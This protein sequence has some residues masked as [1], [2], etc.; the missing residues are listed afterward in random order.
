MAAKPRQ[1]SA[2]PQGRGVG[3]GARGQGAW[4]GILHSAPPTHCHPIFLNKIKTVACSK[5]PAPDYRKTSERGCGGGHGTAY[6]ASRIC[7]RPV[8]SAG[9][10]SHVHQGMASREATAL[11]VLALL[12]REF[13][14]LDKNPLTIPSRTCLVNFKKWEE[15]RTP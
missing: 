15:C 12:P 11:Q 14:S 9:Q 2:V 4:P 7:T 5:R 10:A 8:T 13:V 3:V 6:S 1:I